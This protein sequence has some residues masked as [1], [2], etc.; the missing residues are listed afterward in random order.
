[1][2]V[3]PHLCLP[4]AGNPEITLA[5]DVG[6]VLC[7]AVGNLIVDSL[8]YSLTVWQA[9]LEMDE[10][11]VTVKPLI[12][13]DCT[14][15]PEDPDHES[16]DGEL[17]EVVDGKEDRILLVCENRV[18]VLTTLPLAPLDQEPFYFLP[19]I[20]GYGFHRACTGALELVH[21][22]ADGEVIL[23]RK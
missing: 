22:A 1:M 3:I 11:R 13:G 19:V 15:L 4:Q 16:A 7:K 2:R 20:A 12:Q 9:F 21:L 6:E 8:V 23:S 10:R 14:Y 5:V 17:I 18:A